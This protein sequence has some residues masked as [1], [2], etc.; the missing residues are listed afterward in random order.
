M[1]SRRQGFVVLGLVGGVVAGFLTRP[2][3]PMV[4]QLPFGVVI[5]RGAG[6]KGFDQILVGAAQDSF[7]HLMLITILGVALGFAMPKVIGLVKGE[8]AAKGETD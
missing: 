4:G 6:L 5:T 3:V 8:M 1:K 2:S 7:N